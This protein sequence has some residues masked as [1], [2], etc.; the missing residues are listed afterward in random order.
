MEQLR[1]LKSLRGVRPEFQDYENADREQL[2]PHLTEELARKRKELSKY[3]H[4][5]KTR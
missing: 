2:P 4:R 3:I 5:M 1:L